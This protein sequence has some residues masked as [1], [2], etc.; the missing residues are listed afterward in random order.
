V[1]TQLPYAAI[2]ESH[3]GLQKNTLEETMGR[4]IAESRKQPCYLEVFDGATQRFLF[5]RDGQIYASGAIGVTGAGQYSDS[6]I[7]DFLLAVDRMHFPQLF[8]YALDIKTLHS[9]LIL[10]QKKPGLCIQTSLVDL[11]ELLDKIEAEGKSC[12]VNAVRDNFL[13]AL[14]YERG[15]T[16]ALCHGESSPEPREASFR[17]EFLVKIYTITAEEPVTIGIYEDLLVSYSSD[18]R[19]IPE[20]FEGSFEELF[21]SKPPMVSL[22]FKDKELDHWVFDKPRL[23]IGRT[24]DNDIIID[25]LAVSRLHAILENEKGSYYIRDCDSL[26]G[27][28]VNGKKVGR[29]RLN[30][31]DVVSIGKH[32]I[33]FRRQGGRAVPAGDAIDGFDQTMVIMTGAQPVPAPEPTSQPTRQPRLVIKTE[34]GD[35]IVQID[36]DKVTIGRDEGA[37]IAID[38]VFVAKLHAEIVRNEDRF[39]IRHVGGLRKVTVGGKSV[40]EVELS[41]NDEIKIAKGEFIFQE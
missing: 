27:T 15:V 12:I 37:D 36:K 38:G 34:W 7:R 35:R 1:R 4:A 6:T 32:S 19:T 17:E 41:D 21:L 2:I 11:D 24:P 28:V 5:F 18:A 40:R 10:F 14:R 9:I 20:G 22:R 23:K 13:A 26:N 8:W 30:D 16:T 25:N 39:I 31:G 29:A 3:D 33:V